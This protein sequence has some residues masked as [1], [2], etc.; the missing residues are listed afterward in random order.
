MIPSKATMGQ[1]SGTSHADPSRSPEERTKARAHQ[2]LLG[3]R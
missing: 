2:E 3:T 1:V